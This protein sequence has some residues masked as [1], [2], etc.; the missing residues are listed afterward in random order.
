MEVGAFGCIGFSFRVWLWLNLQI[1]LNAFSKMTWTI[2]FLDY[3]YPWNW[4]H[5]YLIKICSIPSR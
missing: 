2:D 4:R 5:S 3:L 1:E